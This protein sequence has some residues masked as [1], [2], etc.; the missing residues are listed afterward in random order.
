MSPTPSSFRY[1][2]DLLHNNNTFKFS[3]VHILISVMICSLTYLFLSYTHQETN[4]HALDTIMNLAN[5]MR[6]NFDGRIGEIDFCLQ[7]ATDG[8]VEQKRG[9]NIQDLTNYLDKQKNRISVDFI[10]ASDEQGDIIYGTDTQG[11]TTN[12]ADREYF[13]YLR[14]HKDA[15]L[16]ISRPAISRIANKKV[17]LFVRRVTD[18]NGTFLGIVFAGIFT[19]N[20]TQMINEIK[21]SRE[22]TI[23]LFS[24]DILITQTSKRDTGFG[25]DKT[26]DAD[27][28]DDAE[29]FMRDHTA[30][31]SFVDYEND[32]K[33]RYIHW[34]SGSKIYDFT[35]VVKMADNAVFHEWIYYTEMI[36]AFLILILSVMTYAVYS[37]IVSFNQQKIIAHT[38]KISSLVFEN[39]KEAI[40]ITGCDASF[41]H[42]NQ[43]FCDLTGYTKQEMI[44]QRPSILRSGEHSEIFYRTMWDSL[45][46]TGHWSGEISNKRK[47]G[48]TFIGIL[49]ISAVYDDHNSISNYI[50]ITTD[51]TQ[52]KQIDLQLRKLSQ[53]VEQSPA[54][55]MIADTAGKI[56]YVNKKFYEITGYHQD[57]VIGKNPRFLKSGLTPDDVYR[58]LWGAIT[59][60]REWRGELQ[61]RKKNGELF[62]EFASFSPLKEE[63]GKITH[64]IAVKE[65]ITIR[66]EYENRLIKQ[67]N[68]DLLTGLPN[69]L[70][71]MDRL[72]QAM[73]R[74]HREKQRVGIMFIDLDHFK[75]VNDTLGHATGDILLKEAAK[76]LTTAVRETD[77][78]ARLGGDEFMMILADLHEATDAEVVAEKVIALC[79]SLFQIEDHELQLSASVGITIYPDDGTDPHILVRNA[80]LAM[81]QSKEEGRG[82][83]HFFT[84]AMDARAHE[85]MVFESELRYAIERNELS[86]H[87]QP[88]VEIASNR[89][90]GAEALIRWHNK[91][92]GPISPTKFIPIA[93]NSGLIVPIG[94]WILCKACCD[95]ARWQ[96]QTGTPI[97]VAVNVSSRQFEKGSVLKTVK[98]ALG[99]TG[100]PAS[101][102]KLEITEGVL[103]KESQEVNQIINNICA[104]GVR[105]AIDDFGTGYS[106]LSYLR[107]LPFS[108]LKID[109]SFVM[110]L[111]D[112]QEAASL[113]SAIVSMAH[114]L[115]MNIVGE[116]VETVAQ[117]DFLRHIGCDIS[118]GWLTGKPM[119]AHEFVALLEQQSNA[120]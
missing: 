28:S 23:A 97:H 90:V 80:D 60:G 27:D 104:L 67:A 100:L 87:Y 40:A 7:A 30:E 66:K 107:R 21:T 110:D 25:S 3:A 76:R 33:D 48:D 5:S 82:A 8:I 44:G 11:K 91:K 22:E 95:A 1:V 63:D 78:V 31:G 37:F 34:Y 35:I 45:G 105:L 119:P 79:G 19:D 81:Y 14:D 106:S 55:V 24:R 18:E 17:V 32:G 89:I 101:L 98:D 39:A 72:S 47:N 96:R 103:L 102:L 85:I 65:N 74:A 64:Y 13:I 38:T 70:L 62:W 118:Q 16:Y 57:D 52:K 20:I 108:T 92:F 2:I 115:R 120:M 93:E 73:S 86:I 116:G 6:Q 69:R 9:N 58:E 111:P 46:A 26:D 54:S 99:T 42:V 117:K 77:T 83:F 15:G 71:A 88:L 68:F 51:I 10:R 4:R 75:K 114:G 56:V 43:A 61:N 50:A 84:H 94:E 12:V 49:S 36:V 53:S 113:V 109:R 41:L 29:H 59:S 112:S